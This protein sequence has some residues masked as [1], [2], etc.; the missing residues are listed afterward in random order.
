MRI[1]A[2]QLSTEEWEATIGEQFRSVRLAAGHDQAG[3][4]ALASVSIGALRNLER[5]RGSTLGTIIR[6]TRALGREDWLQ[7]ISPGSSVSPLDLVRAT[8]TTRT[9]VYRPRR[10]S[11]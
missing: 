3:L 7:S 1:R 5:G 11:A 6:V 8:T 10:D 2:L 9:R 4:A